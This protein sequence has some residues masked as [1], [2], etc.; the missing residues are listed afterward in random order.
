MKMIDD[1]VLASI[2]GA[3][4][5]VELFGQWPSFH[6]AEVLNL[7]LSRVCESFMDVHTFAMTSEV[8]AN[9][10]YICD[11]HTV[12]TFHFG[13][14]LGMNLDGFNHQNVIAGL[15]I[16]QEDEG[17]RLTLHPCYGLAGEIL[18]KSLSI[19][20]EQGIPPASGYS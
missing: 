6:D 15:D 3:E 19:T 5:L 4:F 8:D 16:K 18:V 13:E 2:A 10:I 20:L 1:A 17:L 9:G 11:R 12:V 7:K 14:I